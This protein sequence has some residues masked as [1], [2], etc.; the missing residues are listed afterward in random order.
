[1]EL[2]G[3]SH[4]PRTVAPTSPQTAE[5]KTPPQHQVPAAWDDRFGPEE[6][7]RPLPPPD[8]LYPLRSGHWSYQ[9]HSRQG[10]PQPASVK[11]VPAGDDPIFPFRRHTPD[12]RIEHIG[13]NLD[14]AWV[15]GATVDTKHQAKTVYTPPM[16]M[17]PGKLEPGREL[18]LKCKMVVQ[19]AKNPNLIRDRGHCTRTMRCD[20][21]Q[22][23]HT[24]AGRFRCYRIR[25]SLEAKLGL[26]SVRTTST[27]WYSV[28]F[29][30]VAA[31]HHERVQTA[32]LLGWESHQRLMLKDPEPRP[33]PEP[34]TDD[35]PK[36]PDDTDADDGGVDQPARP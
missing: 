3:C 36:A 12:G 17:V 2:T 15:I 7:A 35:A 27:L 14:G 32:I 23:V 34:R 28:G 30:P 13:K 11:V 18:K 24:P 26:A 1:M 25:T 5:P 4:P 6:P 16:V 10:K 31:H 9:I 29:G 21:I 33:L 8:Q 19:D 22:W 20:A